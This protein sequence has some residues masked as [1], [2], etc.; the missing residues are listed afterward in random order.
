MPLNLDAVGTLSDPA[1]TSWDS[2]DA[3]LYALGV[4][5]GT[6]EQAFVTENSID[7]DQEVLPTMAVVIPAIGGGMSNLGDFNWA[8]L[9]HGEQGVRLHSPSRSA[10]PSPAR[11]RSPASTTRA[12]A[13][14]W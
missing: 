1:E 12:R 7:L 5:S 6:D 3:I 8:M 13:P 4:G 2:K 10:G 14:S 11:P 9:V